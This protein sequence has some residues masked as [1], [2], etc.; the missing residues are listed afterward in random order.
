MLDVTPGNVTDYDYIL[1]KIQALQTDFNLY[2][3][4]IYYDSWNA[5]QFAI[6][7]TAQGL[8]MFPYSQSIGSFNKP[9]KEFERLI[10]SDKMIID[11]NDITRWC[12]SNVALKT[13]WNENAKPVKAGADS[14]K[15][16]GVISMIQA[17]AG[18]LSTPQYD[19][20]ITV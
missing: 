4:G 12:I 8:P 10:K 17:L 3:G 6:N 13:D 7:A 18:Y 20:S 11:N 16:D 2:I 5:T 15:I 9:T 14:E 19:N 1:N